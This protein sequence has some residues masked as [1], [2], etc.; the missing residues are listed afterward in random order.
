M[1]FFRKIVG[2]RLY[3]SPFNADAPESYTKWAEWMNERTVADGYGGYHNLVSLSSA[4]KTVA[5]LKDYRFD[6]VLLDGDELIGFAS[7]HDIDHR[8]RHAFI[9]IFIGEAAYRGKGYGAEAVRLILEYGF[10]ALNLHNIALSVHGDNLEAIRC[11]Q[12]VGFKEAGR[13]RD[14]LFKNG[15]YVDVVYMDILAREFLRE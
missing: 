13:R 1:R 14:W 11:Y 2:E 9:G 15:Q 12:K 7:L 3:L 6:I 10:N 8:S 4:K 5:E